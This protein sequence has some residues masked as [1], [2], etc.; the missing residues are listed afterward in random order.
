MSNGLRVLVVDEVS[1]TEEV[2]KA[3][4]EP[5]GLRVD[6]VRAA[7][8]S[9]PSPTDE[10]DV[11]VIDLDDAPAGDLHCEEW[12]KV[13]QVIIGAVFRPQAD[14]AAGDADRQFLQKPFEYAELVRMIE[15]LIDRRRAG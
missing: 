11:V 2:L 15:S 9:F 5:R 7:A 13:P 14:K 1:D 10:P 6:R 4:L 3:V 8:R 12:R